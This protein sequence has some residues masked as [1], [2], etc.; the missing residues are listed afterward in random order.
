MRVERVL[1][2][3]GTAMPARGIDDM[4]EPDEGPHLFKRLV[5][6]GVRHF[7]A[8]AISSRMRF[9]AS[10]GVPMD[11]GGL[12]IGR[13][14]TSC[15]APARMASAGVIVRFWSPLSAQLGRTPGVTRAKG[16][17]ALMVS[18]KWSS[19]GEQMMPSAPAA[20]AI[21]AN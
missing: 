9:A 5:N 19:R 14:I 7:S 13:P 10:T 8:S 4:A 12:R 15:V 11:E 20:S 6:F 2:D 1:V 3:V 17:G 18:S 21:V 16:R